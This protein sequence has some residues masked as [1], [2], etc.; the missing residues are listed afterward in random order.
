MSHAYKTVGTVT[1]SII[2]Y[3]ILL[4]ILSGVRIVGIITL[5]ARIV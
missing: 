2:H 3:I 5:I 4:I 1:A